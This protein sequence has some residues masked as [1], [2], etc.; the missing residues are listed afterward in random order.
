[1]QTISADRMI[2]A[3]LSILTLMLTLISTLTMR[4]MQTDPL[5][6]MSTGVSSPMSLQTALLT[7]RIAA[8]RILPQSTV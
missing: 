1:M 3:L 6:S 2:S 7:A 5:K 4:F 8:M